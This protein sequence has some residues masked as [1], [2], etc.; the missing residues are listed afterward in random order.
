MTLPPHSHDDDAASP[1]DAGRAADTQ[2]LQA[3]LAGMLTLTPHAVIG[4]DPQQRITL[5]TPLAEELFGY[6][7]QELLGQPLAVLLP[8]LCDDDALAG[9]PV[10]G[11]HMTT[12]VRRG[13]GTFDAMAEIARVEVPGGAV[14]T[15][16]VREAPPSDEPLAASTLLHIVQDAVIITDPA[17]RITGWNPAAE[18]LYGWSAAEALGQPAHALLQ[19]DYLG[20]ERLQLLQ[21]LQARGS[22]SGELVHR[23]RDGRA[24]AIRAT[25][26]WMR[27]PDGAP[28]GAISVNRDI[29]ERKQVEQALRESEQNLTSV[30]ASIDARIWSV[31]RAGRLIVANA[32]FHRD[33]RAILERDVLPGESLWDLSLPPEWQATWRANYD[34]ALA[35]ETFSVERQ[36]AGI[37]MVYRFTPI[38]ARD[39]SVTGVTVLG[40]DLSTHRSTE[41][42][43]QETERKLGALFELLP[44]GVSILDAERTVAYAN[45]ALSQILRLDQAGLA[46][47]AYQQRRYLHSDGT[48]L[49]A[50][51]FASVR[52]FHEHQP[53]TNVETGI[54]T[55]SGEVI[56]TSVSAAPVDFPDWRIVVVTT[57]ITARIQAEAALRKSVA[58]LQAALESM[59]DAVFISDVEG[60]FID[61]NAAFATFHRFPSKDACATTLAEYPAFL[62]VYLET[63]E[64]AP[65]EQWAVPRALRG[66]TIT[67][68]EYTLRR[69]DTGETWIGSYSFAPIR[70][71]DG[72]TIGSV[73]VGRDITERKQAEQALAAA[74]ARLRVLSEASRAFAEAGLAY[75]PL[76]DLVAQRVVEALCD[77]CIIRMRS[78]DGHWLPIVA[79]YHHDAS[80]HDAATYIRTLVERAPLR[81]D[82]PN[83]DQQIF[84]TGTPLLVPVVDLAQ[85]K[86]HSK[87]EYAAGISRF[88]PHSMIIVPLRSEGQS[89]GILGMYRSR[90]RWP[91]FGDD[92]LRL[93]QDL[94]DRAATAIANARLY[95]QAQHDL[96]ERQRAEQALET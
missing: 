95:Q 73:V 80:D 51:E 89:T 26:T 32:I 77:F 76:L 36:F 67:G 25:T 23:H 37:T 52:A 38:R 35:G 48:P 12:G 66:E 83:V 5:V 82:E 6:P 43:L 53:V 3:H 11:P 88:T 24:I 7:R 47:G 44:V 45:P 30:L 4:T 61:F 49:E 96:A 29:S 19:T 2:I 39:G 55:E 31:D 86:A 54:V 91:A 75:Q 1:A 56:W 20:Q 72:T 74:T 50:H 71:A 16:Q 21:E 85:L 79:M 62:E 42:A 69:K 14:W 68:A 18:A 58:T 59:T 41:V 28:L 64:L 78:D 92:D 87:P 34:Q 93:A 65:L 57:D 27:G 8:Q 81:V 94:A 70:D 15:I 84:H 17:L 63:G 46:Q 10:V 40:Q 9:R 33:I 60:R 90:P 13:G 22:W